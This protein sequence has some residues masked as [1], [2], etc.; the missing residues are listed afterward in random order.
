MRTEEKVMYS[1]ARRKD[2]DRIVSLEK[3]V[4][5]YMMFKIFSLTIL[6]YFLVEKLL[7]YFPEEKSYLLFVKSVAFATINFN[8]RIFVAYI[9]TTGLAMLFFYTILTYMLST[10]DKHPERAIDFIKNTCYTLWNNEELSSDD[11]VKRHISDVLSSISA[12]NVSRRHMGAYVLFSLL[13]YGFQL[14][15]ANVL[16]LA[17][18]LALET[19]TLLL[20]QSYGVMRIYNLSKALDHAYYGF[21]KL[22][23]YIDTPMKAVGGTKFSL[24]LHYRVD[25]LI[26]ILGLFATILGGIVAYLVV[27]ANFVK[28]ILALTLYI[29]REWSLE[30]AVLDFFYAV[31]RKY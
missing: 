24:T 9:V 14:S 22:S 20:I 1:Y 27:F 23:R 12:Y 28:F 11:T 3:L 31:S 17:L 10:I 18:G 29:S 25:H 15:G 8:E 19:I 7:E 13:G 21:L 30:D 6:G 2:T 5:P 16:I 4:I 26:I